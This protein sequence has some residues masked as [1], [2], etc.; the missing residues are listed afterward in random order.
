MMVNRTYALGPFAGPIYVVI[1]IVDIA[2]FAL[3]EWLIPREQIDYVPEECDWT[4]ENFERFAKVNI[5]F[6][7]LDNIAKFTLQ[8]VSDNGDEDVHVC[9][10]QLKQV[11]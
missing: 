8:N 5:C 1:L 11:Y 6:N 2:F 7:L 10:L 9:V 3:L 4:Q